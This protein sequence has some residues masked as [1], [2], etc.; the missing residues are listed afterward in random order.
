MTDT[1][2]TKAYCMKCD[3]LVHLPSGFAFTGL[4][5]EDKFIASPAIWFGEKNKAIEVTAAQDSL[6]LMWHE[7]KALEQRKIPYTVITGVDF[8][9]KQFGS[10]DSS[11]MFTVP[12]IAGLFG[13]LVGTIALAAAHST[14]ALPP[15]PAYVQTLLIR[16]NE[17]DYELFVSKVADWAE[18]LCR[19]AGLKTP[20]LP[21][22]VARLSL[23][24]R[25]LMALC[26]R[27]GEPISRAAF[28]CG[29]CGESMEKTDLGSQP[30]IQELI[31]TGK[32][33]YRT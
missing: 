12:M 14:G 17:G 11:A 24:D 25:R 6:T 1:T 5:D 28:Q 10:K 22:G 8:G 3:I 21:P 15:G 13:P 33:R 19:K 16:T 27:C 2:P 20:Q 26:P 9:V 18:R 32:I 4:P 7:G 29:S 30:S 23:E 31:E